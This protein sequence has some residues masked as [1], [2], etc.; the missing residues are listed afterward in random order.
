MGISPLLARFPRGSCETEIYA[1]WGMSV[2]IQPVAR[3][4]KSSPKARQQQYGFLVPAVEEHPLTFAS[5]H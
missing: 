5:N 3:A 1:S 2:P 4:I